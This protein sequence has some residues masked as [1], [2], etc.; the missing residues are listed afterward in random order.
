MVFE[1]A[2][3]GIR[4]VRIDEYSEKLPLKL[5]W[6]ATPYLHIWLYCLWGQYSLGRGKGGRGRVTLSGQGYGA[7]T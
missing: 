3:K 4:E 6:I 7:G 5:A 1:M 2:E